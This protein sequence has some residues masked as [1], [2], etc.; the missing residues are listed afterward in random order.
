MA[1][2]AAVKAYEPERVRP[3]GGLLES[4]SGSD[5]MMFT[6][7]RASEPLPALPARVAHHGPS[8]IVP[9]AENG[10]RG[11]APGHELSQRI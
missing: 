9:D 7:A 3:T 5:P 6:A 10:G 11:E 2:R 8:T 1:G 4:R